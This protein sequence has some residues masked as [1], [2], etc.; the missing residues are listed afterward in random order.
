MTHQK[1]QERAHT[2]R[3]T[4]SKCASMYHI[5]PYCTILHHIVTL[6]ASITCLLSDLLDSTTQHITAQGRIQ[7]RADSPKKQERALRKR[8]TIYSF[9]HMYNI[10]LLDSTSQH[11]EEYK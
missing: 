7:M 3:V 4:I 1:K 11:R 8:V 9:M 10:D 5:A 6:V 2:K